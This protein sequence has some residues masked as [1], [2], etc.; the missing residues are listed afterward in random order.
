MAATEFNGYADQVAVPATNVIPIPARMSFDEAAAVP[1]NYAT[2]WSAL[3]DH[4]N[5]QP[6]GR[7]LIH[8]AA[9]GVGIAAT[10]IA[11]RFGAEVYGTASPAKHG[12]IARIGVDHAIDYR[13][14][15]WDGRL[16]SFD[17][18]LDAVG[19]KSFRTSYELLR[20][21]GRLVA[22]GASSVVSG[23]RR[24][25]FAAL[26]MLRGMPRFKL[27]PQMHESKSVI[28]LNM[29]S[30]WRERGSI[31]YWARPL[32]ELLDDGT[33]NPVVA[34]TFDFEHAGDAQEML[35]QR[36]NVGKVV[37]A[38]CAPCSPTAPPRRLPRA[39]P[40]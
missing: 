13:T 11:K 33:I 36:R 35:V 24:N 30:E 29:L 14:N 12:A 16:P 18:V 1:I 39:R 27:I 5:L 4:G 6:G 3:I 37:L 10:Q 15:G 34:D 8:A 32:R 22:Y 2:A 28:G 19:G 20:P 21:G 17:I 23:S 40:H 9:G 31:G 7:V 38:A 25:L 26:R